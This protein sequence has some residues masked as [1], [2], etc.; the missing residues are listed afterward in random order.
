ML[1][2]TLVLNFLAIYVLPRTFFSLLAAIMVISFILVAV[3]VS[4]PPRLFR[5]EIVCME[6]NNERQII[7]M[8]R[9]TGSAAILFSIAILLANFEV[10]S[11]TSINE[12]VLTL[13]SS[14]F[15]LGYGYYRN[16]KSSKFAH[17][18]AVSLINSNWRKKYTR[19]Q[20]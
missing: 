8:L 1:P 3:V 13:L 10:L 20:R 18:I 16:R 4:F 14:A 15:L 11:N 2:I 7:L 5:K 17:E 9:E 6:K 12:V 19:K